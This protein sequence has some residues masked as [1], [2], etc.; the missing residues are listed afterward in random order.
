MTKSTRKS[1]PWPRKGGLHFYAWIWSYFR[2]GSRRKA[3]Q[4]KATRKKPTQ[5]KAPEK[6]PPG[7]K[8]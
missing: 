1:D 5:K 4:K 2:G 7:N 6:M 8:L 3:T